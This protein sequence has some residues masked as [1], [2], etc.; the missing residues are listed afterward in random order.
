[1]DVNVSKQ[2]ESR[3]QQ[4]AQDRGQDAADFAGAIL[5][6]QLHVIESRPTGRMKL[7]DLSGMFYGGDGK[8]AENASEILRAGIKKESGFGG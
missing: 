5:E 2:T 3:I 4:I 8:T 7:S 6:E 1:M